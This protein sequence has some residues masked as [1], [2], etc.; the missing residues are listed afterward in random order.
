MNSRGVVLLFTLT[1]ASSFQASAVAE[2]RGR[3]TITGGYSAP[4]IKSTALENYGVQ[5]SPGGADEAA[6]THQSST[7]HG[8]GGSAG[9]PAPVFT[10]SCAATHTVG[11]QVIA[12]APS[13]EC[14]LA[15]LAAPSNDDDDRGRRRR[16]HP[17]PPSPE[18]LA[19]IAADR[20]IALAPK[21]RLRVAP[22][23]V[24][25]TGLASYFWLARRP[26]AIV[27]TAG[28]PGMTVTAQARPVQFV[29]AFGDGAE[30]V[31][32]RSGR[33]W[34]ARRPGNIG[35]LYETRGRYRT[36]VEVIWEARWRIGGGAWRPLGYFSNADARR[37]RVRQ[38][39]AVLVR[40]R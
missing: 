11:G 35:H 34:R 9:E 22:R 8:G 32:R 30:K 25:L 20:A 37:Y 27:A 28:V 24:G 17:A 7:D 26:R 2:G 19:R 38:V 31:T 13:Q 39:I 36:T 33:R 15:S 12:S 16:G 18:E 14:L 4:G 10:R 23:G 1:L 40:P 21:P 3:A 5:E 29:W 6:P